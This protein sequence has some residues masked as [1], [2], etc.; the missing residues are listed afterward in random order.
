[1]VAIVEEVEHIHEGGFKD[2][3]EEDVGGGCPLERALDDAHLLLFDVFQI[4]KLIALL[5]KFEI[6]GGFVSVVGHVM[7]TNSAEVDTKISCTAQS[8]MWD[9]GNKWS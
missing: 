8:R 4:F 3:A 5:S 7:T 9:T 1:M 2:D 6:P